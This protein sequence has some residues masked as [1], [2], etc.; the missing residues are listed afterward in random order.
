MITRGESGQDEALLDADEGL[1]VFR[2]LPDELRPEDCDARRVLV[3]RYTGRA[4]RFASVSREL[5]LRYEDLFRDL[6]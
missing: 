6:V 5:A 1:R 3:E 4:L 2:A